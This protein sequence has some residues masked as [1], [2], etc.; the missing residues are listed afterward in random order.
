MPAN[1]RWDL[2]RRLRVKK[3]WSVF[4]FSCTL[5]HFKAYCA[6]WVRR[7]NFCHQ[8]S[9]RVSGKFCLNADFHLTFRDLLDAVNLRHGKACWGFLRPKNPTVSAG[10]KRAN[11]G[12]RGQHATS[13][14]LKPLTGVLPLLIPLWCA[15]GHVYLYLC[16][17]CLELGMCTWADCC[18]I[19]WACCWWHSPDTDMQSL[20][21]QP[22]LELC[23]RHCSLC[24]TS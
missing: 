24:P 6:V 8:A 4:I 2:I 17:V 10:W 1:S 18:W 22:P 23:T 15:Q 3:N 11:L 12:T 19:A 7:S 21:S 13:R 16:Y 5:Q 20:C 14:P 9:P